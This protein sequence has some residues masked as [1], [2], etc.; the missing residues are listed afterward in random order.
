MEPPAACDPAEVG[1]YRL[2][3]RAGEPEGWGRCT[4]RSPRRARRATD[5]VVAD[6]VIYFGGNNNRLYALN[7]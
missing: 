3:A 2:R 5:V 6:Q 4:W 7:T 1:A